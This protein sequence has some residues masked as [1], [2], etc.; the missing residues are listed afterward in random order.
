MLRMSSR[1]S[2][3][4]IALLSMLL[5]SI[6][7]ESRAVDVPQSQDFSTPDSIQPPLGWTLVNQDGGPPG[8]GSLLIFE[9][10]GGNPA[11][12]GYARFQDSAADASYVAA[13]ASYLGNWTPL[14]NRGA[15]AFDHQIFAFEGLT[16]HYTIVLK[17]PT[18]DEARWFSPRPAVAGGWQ[19]VE[20]NLVENEWRIVTGSWDSLLQNVSEFRI[21]IEVVSGIESTGIDNIA[22]FPN[23]LYVNF[24]R[25]VQTFD[26]L[27]GGR[28]SNAPLQVCDPTVGAP[29]TCGEGAT[30]DPQ[31]PESPVYAWTDCPE[32]GSSTVPADP[33]TPL[34]Y[35]TPLGQCRFTQVQTTALSGRDAVSVEVALNA[36]RNSGY[37][38]C[39]WQVACPNCSTSGGSTP[40]SFTGKSP[41]F[42][43]GSYANRPPGPDSNLNGRP[44]DC[45]DPDDDGMPTLLDNC[46][47]ANPSQR[48]SDKDGIGDACDPFCNPHPSNDCPEPGLAVMIGS[49]V[50]GLSLAGRRRQRRGR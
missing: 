15:I 3:A 1:A 12:G 14:E 4:W 26:V 46:P 27:A 6:A 5:G 42:R 36:Y 21:S 18:G 13:P 49:A 22:F 17:S 38:C 2:I 8:V 48:D 29:N 31:A 50:I 33:P 40:G 37:M 23:V 43:W 10:L 16:V 39:A 11:S 24:L 20:A 7:A 34:V 32:C 30:C 41:L 45:E 28:C 25:D 19:L 35:D 44:D 47:T 9:P